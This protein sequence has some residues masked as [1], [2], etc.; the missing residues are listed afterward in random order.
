MNDKSSNKKNKK[1]YLDNN[2]LR[3][4]ILRC[5][6]SRI[7]SERLGKMFKLIVDNQARSFFW[8]NPDDGEDCKA[9]AL[10]DLCANFWKFEPVNKK[11]GESFSAFAF[12]SQIAY[13]GIAGAKRILYPKKY[14]GTVSLTCV[15]DS[16]NNYDMYNL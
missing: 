5:K 10:M 8:V 14:D 13:F 6:E 4:E 12:C 1:Y 15:D 16:G 11:T 9:N 7:A 3:D 2:E